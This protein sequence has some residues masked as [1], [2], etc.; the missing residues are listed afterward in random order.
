MRT[1]LAAKP[2]I[3]SRWII[4]LGSLCHLVSVLMCFGAGNVPMILDEGT[5]EAKESHSSLVL[6]RNKPPGSSKYSHWGPDCP[7]LMPQHWPPLVQQDLYKG[8]DTC[9]F[10]LKTGLLGTLKPNKLLWQE[11]SCLSPAERQWWECM[12]S[13]FS[14]P[15]TRAQGSE[16]GLLSILIYC[17]KVSWKHYWVLFSSVPVGGFPLLILLEEGGAE[18]GTI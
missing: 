11:S 14:A 8:T 17:R 5:L 10:I 2:Q 13:G 12:L 16:H 15:C 18:L 3:T 6:R 4:S 1:I 7:I 9:L